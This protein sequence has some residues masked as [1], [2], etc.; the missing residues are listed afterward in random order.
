MAHSK[1]LITVGG[2]ASH[3]AWH[4]VDAQRGV[5]EEGRIRGKEGSESEKMLR[6]EKQEIYKRV[7]GRREIERKRCE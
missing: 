7:V 6:E 2:R 5:S 1:P 4:R 3:S